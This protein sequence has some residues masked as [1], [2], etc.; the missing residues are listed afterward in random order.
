MEAN[1]RRQVQVAV[2]IAIENEDR[3]GLHATYGQPHAPAG[4]EGLLLTAE[5]DFHRSVAGSD[6][7]LNHV[8]HVTDRK[9]N[10][11][12]TR[13]PEEVQQV[14]EEGAAVHVGSTLGRSETTEVSRVPR[15]PASTTASS[16][17]LIGKT[18][19]R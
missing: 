19:V 4:P 3:I 17:P 14:R 11:A 18:G 10:A 9:H 5:D 15:P 8:G 13:I 16:K 12:D 1:E 2:G 7:M 6:A